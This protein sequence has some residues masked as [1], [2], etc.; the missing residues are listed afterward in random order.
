MCQWL[1]GVIR[2]A[3]AHTVMET[4]ILQVSHHTPHA[5]KA[6]TKPVVLHK[7]PGI[8]SHTTRINNNP[9]LVQYENIFVGM[10]SYLQRSNCLIIILTARF[11]D[12]LGGMD[13]GDQSHL[14]CFLTFVAGVRVVCKPWRMFILS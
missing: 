2:E 12:R 4:D 13:S 7:H 8:F 14:L 3:T 1:R 5:R 6:D 11:R 10:I 9:S